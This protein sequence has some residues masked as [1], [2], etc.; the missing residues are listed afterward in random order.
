MN[1]HS[2]NINDIV[3]DNKP[4]SSE[5]ASMVDSIINEL[6]TGNNHPQ[7]QQQQQQQPQ[8]QKHPQ[9]HQHKQQQ[10]EMIEMYSQMHEKEEH[11][12]E[13]IMDQIKHYIFKSTDVF[14]VFLLSIIFNVSSFSEFLKFK[15][16]P[17]LYDIKSETPTYLSVILKAILIALTYAFIKYFIK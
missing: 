14:I 2:T 11:D 9:Q 10:Q 3:N 5:E 7:Q 1:T 16:I 13:N 17:F 6:N 15:S 4:L 8:Q 12:N